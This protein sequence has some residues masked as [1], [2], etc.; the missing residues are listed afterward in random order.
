MNVLS[1]IW[2]I[3]AQ[4]SRVRPLSQV[5]DSRLLRVYYNA[6]NECDLSIATFYIYVWLIGQ[7]PMQ[8]KYS[9]TCLCDFSGTILVIV[10]VIFWPQIFM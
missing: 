3:Q 10:Y 9:C 6:T 7:W 5:C 1:Q 2:A 8:L 4:E